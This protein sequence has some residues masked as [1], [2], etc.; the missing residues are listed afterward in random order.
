MRGQ[1]TKNPRAE[2]PRILGSLGPRFRL[3]ELNGWVRPRALSLGT[4]QGTIFGYV[5]EVFVFRV[6]REKE[7]HLGTSQGTMFGYVPGHYICVSLCDRPA[8]NV[9]SSA[10]GQPTA[11]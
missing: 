6:S 4:C 3:P 10:S 11:G 8:S 2:G 5:G 7:A 9:Q 1:G